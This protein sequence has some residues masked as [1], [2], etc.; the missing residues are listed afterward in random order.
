MKTGILLLLSIAT[1]FAQTPPS[2]DLSY[3][4]TEFP[5]WDI[6]G[7]YT[8]T[9]DSATVTVDIVHSA[10]GKITGSRSEIYKLNQDHLEGYGFLQGVLS[11]TAEGTVFRGTSKN[12]YSGT[13]SGRWATATAASHDKVL[14]VP[15]SLTLQGEAT[16]RM[17]VKG[18]RCTT[19]YDGYQ[20]P[21][22]T[23]M[24]G[25]WGLDLSLSAVGNKLSGTGKITLSNG[26]VLNYVA[27]GRYNS[28]A[29]TSSL[30]LKG[31]V[32]AAG[33]HLSFI[34]PSVDLVPVNIR[35]NVMGQK[36]AFR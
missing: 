26:R 10:K 1:T 15:S 8:R 25:D 6:S 7:H 29:N 16:I 22:V 14:V 19:S 9:V 21:M 33:T 17:C 20:L 30:M 2:G 34:L 31:Q 3:I 4:F 13:V 28:R 5:I 35:G 36:I 24:T 18:S 27:S 32:E 11:S 23:G 12:T